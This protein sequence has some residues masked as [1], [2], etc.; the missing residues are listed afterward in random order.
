MVTYEWRLAEVKAVFNLTGSSQ[1]I[2]K[3]FAS[4][5]PSKVLMELGVVPSLRNVYYS[6]LFG[7]VDKVTGLLLKIHI[8]L[9]LS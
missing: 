4:T 5:S 6:Y 9:A 1:G 7:G 2:F 3:F 8:L